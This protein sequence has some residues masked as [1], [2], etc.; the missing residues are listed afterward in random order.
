MASAISESKLAE[1]L[2]RPSGG[3]PTG[4]ATEDLAQFICN[5]PSEGPS[6]ESSSKAPKDL[7]AFE[8]PSVKPS[9]LFTFGQKPDLGEPGFDDDGELGAKVGEILHALFEGY[10]DWVNNQGDFVQELVSQVSNL[11][12]VKNYHLNVF[13]FSDKKSQF[14]FTN[15]CW[16]VIDDEAWFGLLDKSYQLVIFQSGWFS[17]H[18][19]PGWCNWGYS[20][21]Y[22]TDEGDCG[23]YE[24]DE[25]N[26]VAIIRDGSIYDSSKA[27]SAAYVYGTWDEYD[28]PT[29]KPMLMDNST[30]PTWE[31]E[32]ME[33]NWGNDVIWCG[34]GNGYHKSN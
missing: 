31:T 26:Q 19:D 28:F 7:S 20:W 11:D 33:S 32:Y 3:I 2:A 22:N 9:E 17:R 10:R 29:I 23:H 34:R 16:I 27:T 15:P 30:T 4:N 21:W 8:L 12:S 5:Q 18:G 24:Y 6:Q 1:R 25:H 13:V 14:F